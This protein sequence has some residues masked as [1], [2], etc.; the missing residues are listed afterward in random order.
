MFLKEHLFA[1]LFERN[2]LTYAKREIA[3]VSVLAAIGNVEPMMKGHMNIALNVGVTPNELRNLLAIVEKL[4]G[5]SE[6]DKTAVLETSSATA[7]F[8]KGNVIEGVNFNGTAYLQRLMT[9]SE[10]FD[11]VVSDVIFEPSARNSWHS[12]PGGQIL[13]ATAGKG[14]YQEKGKPIQV[15]KPGDV[16]AIVPDVKHWHGAAPDSGFTHMAINTKVSLGA[17]EWYDPVTDEE[18]NDYKE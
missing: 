13:I 4:V 18:Y 2:V 9:D 12:H 15:L 11:V 1:D 8:P 17:T 16:I 7:I 5:R 6:A 10:T 3:T 14:Y